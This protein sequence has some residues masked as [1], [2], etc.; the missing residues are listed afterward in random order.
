LE[1]IGQSPG[2]WKAEHDRIPPELA[3]AL[4]AEVQS[5]ATTNRSPVSIARQL[6]ASHSLSVDPG[7]IRHWMVGDRKV[8][9]R[10]AFKQGPSHALSYIIGANIGDG[11]TLTENWIVKLEVTDLDFAEAFNQSVASLFSRSNPNKI[12]V[13]R[14]KVDRLP[15]FVV[16]YSS[17]QLVKLLRLPMKKLLEIAFVYPREFL[18]GFFDAE[19]HVDVR[20]SHQF[21]VSTGVENSSRELLLRIKRVLSMTF[22]IHSTFSKKRKSGTLKVIRGKSFRMKKPSFTLLIQRIDDLR[23]FRVEIGFSI[24]RKNHKLA[25][26]LMVSEDYSPKERTAVWNQLYIKSKGEWVRR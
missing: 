12:L 14:F 2:S 5:L 19:G 1:R 4:Y 7:T 13:K 18:R 6:S 26:A 23:R 8:Q 25:D 22:R 21:Q 16:R 20:A 10:N 15:M 9:R 3:S 24:P 17:K 11:C